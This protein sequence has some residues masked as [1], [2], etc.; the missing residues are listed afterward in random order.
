MGRYD[1]EIAFADRYTGFLVDYLRYLRPLWDQTIFVFT[2][3]HGEEFGEHGGKT[4][5]YTCHEESTHVPLLVRIPGVAGQRIEARVALVDIVPT[6]LEAIGA[7]PG[8]M[9][10]D[11]E[12]LLLPAFAPS[13]V[14]PD[15]PVFCSVLSQKS[16][17]GDFFR[18]SVRSGDRVL[19]HDSATGRLELYDTTADRAEKRDLVAEGDLREQATVELL[20]GALEASMTG[21]LREL[22][23]TAGDDADAS[24]DPL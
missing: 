9:R 8:G 21:N 7:G 4:H 19:F 22:R 5:A 18:Q 24:E 2:A 17:Q 10:L 15:R 16:G 6:I 20:K 11:G 14:D 1:G 23:L 13:S 3:D 12:S